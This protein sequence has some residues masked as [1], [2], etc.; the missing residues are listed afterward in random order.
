MLVFVSISQT[1][2]DLRGRILAWI[3]AIFE[4]RMQFFF[5]YLLEFDAY[6]FV[7][8]NARG[9]LGDVAD[10][11]YGADVDSGGC[12][13]LG[14]AICC[15]SILVGVSCGVVGLSA[16]SEYAGCGGKEDEVVEVLGEVLVE[17]PGAEDFG[18]Y[19]GHVVFV[20]HIFEDGIL[21]MRVS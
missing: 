3:N 19:G 1:S 18:V 12:K 16:V 4:D 8:C 17:V 21:D 13:A 20:G 6:A 11:E 10:G 15:E 5:A 14:A 9:V 2:N 7:D